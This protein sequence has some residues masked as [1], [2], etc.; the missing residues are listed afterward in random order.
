LA[1]SIRHPGEPLRVL[2]ASDT[3]PP[4]I[5]GAARFTERLAGG[6]VRNGNNVHV[7]APAI[8]KNFGTFIETH[9]G[10]EMTVHRLRSRKLILHKTLR[11]VSPFT[12]KNKIEPIL[13]SFQPDAI[14]SQSHI[15]LGRALAKSGHE[16]GITL[17]ATNHLMPENLL[18]YAPMPKFREKRFIAALWTHSRRDTTN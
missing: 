3:F 2:I 10:V 1:E 6:L 9:D 13:E 15:S 14:H 12:L 17:I 8:D 11:F 18:R 16:R 4:D 5:N 7:I